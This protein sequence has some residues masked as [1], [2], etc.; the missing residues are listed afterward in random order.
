MSGPGNPFINSSSFRS[1][2][3]VAGAA[4]RGQRTGREY[5]VL[6][7]IA[8]AVR[9]HEAEA[10]GVFSIQSAPDRAFV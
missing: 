10:I 1:V 4:G 2:C 5:L 3:A 7:R 9:L 8:I 6:A